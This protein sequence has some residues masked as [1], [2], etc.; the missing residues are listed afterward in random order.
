M[1]VQQRISN[2]E[3]LNVN[4]KITPHFDIKI[5]NVDRTSQLKRMK[6]EK[7]SAV[8]INVSVSAFSITRCI[9]TIGSA[10]S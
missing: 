6:R 3:T 9:V 10:F 5:H 8:H 4:T 1:C 7:K 2:L